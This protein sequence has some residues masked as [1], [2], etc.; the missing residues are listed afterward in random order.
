MGGFGAM[1]YAARHPG[2]FAAA[3][4]FSG[5][6]TPLRNAELTRGIV[7]F[8]GGDPDALWGSP[9]A[10]RKVWEAHDPLTLA[11]RLRGTR[12]FVSSGNGQ[13]GTVR[14]A[15]HDRLRRRRR[16]TARTSRSRAGCAR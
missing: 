16:S 1:S 5:V 6:V 11:P 7:A 9:T 3:A 13:A 10:D 12:L 8:G 15:R 2:T 4:S 14:R